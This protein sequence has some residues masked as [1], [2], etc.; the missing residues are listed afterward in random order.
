M[1]VTFDFDDTLTATRLD[2]DWGIRYMGP[3]NQA[4]AKLKQHANDGDTVHIV[5][6]R[7]PHQED[8]LPEFDEY[9]RV[10]RHSV[11]SFL[12][13]QDIRSY[14]KDI[15][16]TDGRLKSEVLKRLGA[17]MH[18]DDSMEELGALH[19][20]T[21]GIHVRDGEIIEQPFRAS[22]HA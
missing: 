21:L 12:E 18:Y 3:N 2:D 16:F 6:S 5:T 15:H 1:I 8:R 4:I 14:I 17:N 9:G 19:D 11:K 22:R 20:D 13:E 7:K 10:I